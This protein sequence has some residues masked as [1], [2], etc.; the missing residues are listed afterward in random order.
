MQYLALVGPVG[1]ACD[2]RSHILALER[3]SAD[4]ALLTGTPNVRPLV[5]SQSRESDKVGAPVRRHESTRCW[6][7]A[8]SK[9]R[10]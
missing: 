9:R 4:R 5:L 2:V 7:N 8:C 3:E 1:A 10:D 6:Q